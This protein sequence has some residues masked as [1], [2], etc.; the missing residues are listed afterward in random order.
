MKSKEKKRDKYID[1]AREPKKKKKAMEREDE[2][3]SPDF[4]AFDNS[5]LVGITFKS[6]NESFEHINNIL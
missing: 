4:W 2:G 3:D 5:R 1:L 6:M